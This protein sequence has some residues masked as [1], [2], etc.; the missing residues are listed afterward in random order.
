MVNTGDLIERWTNGLFRSS[1]HRVVN[2]QGAAALRDRYSLVLFHSPN[3]DA[4]VV[5]LEP[6]QS[7]ERPARY[8]PITAGAH[9]QARIEASRR[10]GYS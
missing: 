1:P 3:R 2:P 7:A 6:C 8:P 4:P 10:E 5:C 9:M